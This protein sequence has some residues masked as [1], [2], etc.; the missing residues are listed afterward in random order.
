VALAVSDE[1][2]SPVQDPGV[3]EDEAVSGAEQEGQRLGRP[4]HHLREGPVGGVEPDDLVRRQP[5]RLH[6]RAAEPDLPDPAAWIEADHRPGG[7]QLGPGVGVG[8]GHLAAGQRG[9][10]GGIQS[11]QRSR[12]VETVDEDGRAARDGIVQAVQDL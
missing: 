3:V 7:P 12:R 11:A 8:E 9:E 2:G 5:R 1:P 6:V 4:L 10:R